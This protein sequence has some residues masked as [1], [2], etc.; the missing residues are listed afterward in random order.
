MIMRSPVWPSASGKRLNSKEE[1]R[2]IISG[3]WVDKIMVNG[4]DSLTSDDSLVDLWEAESKQSSPM[5]SPRSLSEASKL[6][7]EHPFK[8]TL[9][10]SDSQDYD[11]AITGDF[12]DLLEVATSDTS[13]SD[14]HW[15]LQMLKPTSKINGI[16][17][18]A[19]KTP[20]HPKIVKNVE[21]R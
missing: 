20:P 18:K 5:L 4:I 7:L 12:D 1:D 3:D 13:E 11:M 16:V 2:D 9:N 10:R 8:V 15:Q 14:L 21:T 6:C 19:R 17:S